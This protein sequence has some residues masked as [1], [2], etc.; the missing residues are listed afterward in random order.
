MKKK[1]LHTGK[2]HLRVFFGLLSD[3]KCGQLEVTM[4]L[5]I[6]FFSIHIRSVIQYKVSFLLTTLGQFLVSFNVFLGIYFMF[7]RFHQVKGYNYSEALLCFSIVVMSF[8]I[9]ELFLRG[10]D[11][12]SATI[13]N[14][15]F[16]RILLRPRNEVFLVLAG[17][18]EFTR[19]GRIIQ[20]IIILIYGI[21]T[22]KIVW[23]ADKILTMLLMIIGGSVIFGCLFVIYAGIC[24]FTLEGLEF[25]N[26]L[27]DG[28]KEFGKYP[29]NIYGKNVL[30]FCTYVIPYALFQYY[31][32]MYL[33]GRATNPVYIVLPI[34]TCFF[35]I[36]TYMLWSR[37]VRHYQSTGS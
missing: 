24:F 18:I 8:S 3:H 9:A 7:Q 14:G 10:F 13:S 29:M 19:V 4:K 27:T 28:A 11:L 17:K 34:A 30:K 1:H 25:M 36:P 2:S 35:I 15:E 23:S 31:P 26:I 12:F 32:F 20:T 5:Y 33:I 22:S 16:D 37:G 21:V 6:R